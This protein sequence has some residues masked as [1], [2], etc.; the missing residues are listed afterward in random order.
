MRFEVALVRPGSHWKFCRRFFSFWQ[1]WLNE[2]HAKDFELFTSEK[3]LYT[4]HAS[5][6]ICIRQK[7]KIAEKI[8]GVNQASVKVQT[9]RTRFDNAKRFFS[10]W[11][12]IK[13]PMI[14]NF[15]RYAD[16]ITQNVITR[17]K[18]IGQWKSKN[19]VALSNRV[20]CVWTLKLSVLSFHFQRESKAVKELALGG[21]FYVLGVPLFKCDGRIPFAHA[22]WHLF[23]VCGAACHFYA[24]LTYLYT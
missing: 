9:H 16:Q 5:S 21:A 18:V 12:L 15:E 19:R 10:F 1:M 6:L 22:L 23:V 24:V 11:K 20:R 8:A 3:R 7:H 13:Q 2:W 17:I 4:L 14:A